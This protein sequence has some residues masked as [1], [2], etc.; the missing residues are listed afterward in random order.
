[1]AELLNNIGICYC[2]MKEYDKAQ[3]Y[4]AEALE[5]LIEELGYD[6]IDV[7]FCWH[8]LGES[9]LIYFSL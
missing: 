3:V 2:G 1:M 6:H 8:S 7:G 5:S 4:H 9:S